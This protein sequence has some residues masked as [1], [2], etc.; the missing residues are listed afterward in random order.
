MR[1]VL[2]AITEQLNKIADD[3]PSKENRLIEIEV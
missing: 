1:V 2:D 3:F